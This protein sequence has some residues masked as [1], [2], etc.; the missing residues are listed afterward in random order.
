M[1]KVN[2]LAMWTMIGG[3][4][5]ATTQPAIS[6][7]EI[8][9]EE[10]GPDYGTM[11]GDAVVGKPLQLITAVA[12][13]VTYAL[14]YPFSYY[15]GNVEQ[16]KN[17]LVYEPWDAMYRCLGC[18]VSEDK[19]YKSRNIPPNAKRMVIDGQYEVSIQTD[20]IVQVEDPSGVITE[21]Q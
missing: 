2:K 10:F 15:G 12:G 19:Y 5:L 6:A 17:K 11:V 3:L 7:I 1:A 20:D 14:S 18:T 8:N 16:A 4:L 13:S 21:N 9:D